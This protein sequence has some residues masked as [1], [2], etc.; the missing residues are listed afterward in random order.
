MARYSKALAALS[1]VVVRLGAAMEDGSL[2]AGELRDVA[3][4]AVTAV[5]VW[6]VP[7]AS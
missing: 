4:L 7:N 2:T 3:L 6:L 5:F 1:A